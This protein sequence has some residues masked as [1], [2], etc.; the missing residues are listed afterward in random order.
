[1]PDIHG[2]L[3]GVR[4]NVI[5]ELQTLFDYPI[6]RDEYLPLELAQLLG[7]YSCALNREISLYISRDGE[8]ID[9]TVGDTASV[10]LS[11]IRLRRSVRRLARVRCV[12][13]HPRGSAELSDVDITALKSLWLDSM[14]ALGVSLDGAITGL[15]ASFL[16]ERVN[17][18]PQP[19]CTPII[20][21]RRLPQQEWMNEILLSEQRV[22]QGEDKRQEDTPER[23]LLVGIDSQASL[24]EL[25]ALAES[26]GA[27]VVGRSFQRKTKPDTATYIG[28]GKAE[29]LALD[30]Q[31]LEA[32][33]IVVD[34]E[35]TGAQLHNLED[36]ARV[37]VVD[38]TMLILDIFAQRAKTAEGRLQVSLA[39]LRY[40]S[41]RLIGQGLV[42]SRLA[43][44][45][46]TRG[47]GES[48]L[49]IDRRRIREKITQLRR[50]LAEL[51]NQRALRR[52]AR[53]RST[54]PVV[55]LVGYTNTGKSTL[56]N[57]LTGADVYTQDRLFAT[58]D[59]V[60]RNVK[61][62]DGGEFLLVDTVGFI[63]KLPTELVEAFH[64]TLEEAA[65]ADVLVI[66]G[67]ASSPDMLEQHA[68]VEEVLQKLDAAHQPRIDVLNKCDVAPS[69][70]FS[71]LTHA[72]RISAKTGEGLETLMGA[73]ASELRNR[74]CQ[75]TVIV[76]FDQYSIIAEMRQV[77]RVLSEEYL[78]NGTRVTVMLKPAAYG[79]L[80]A[81]YPAIMSGDA[82]C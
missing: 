29:E 53:Q 10:P 23:A 69:E 12:H 15:Q 52:K 51:E 41:G 50:E 44:G 35:L 73:I 67:D 26:A 46:G 48:K 4:K 45:I 62:P 37:K 64:S 72:I 40:Q 81:R 74:E 54:V 13:T 18:E 5:A 77:G 56:L 27:V 79:R 57:R 34:D 43:G 68:V 9:I 38:R 32:D 59:A 75:I 65:L 66:V 49:E 21:L 58:L 3:E 31:A 11:D 22:L 61:L 55:A 17:G 19:I 16:R 42:L 76:P 6:G 82:P 60:S 33:V 78:E 1:M 70:D 80:S 47:P 39:Q 14:C 63:R 30:A 36:I 7:R 24:D 20:P 71:P 2:N 25:A 28:S 8:I